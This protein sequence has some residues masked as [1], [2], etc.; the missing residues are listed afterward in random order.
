LLLFLVPCIAVV[1]LA[2][3]AGRVAYRHLVPEWR[4]VEI[5]W[6]DGVMKSQSIAAV[7]RSAKAVVLGD[8]V[9]LRGID[10]ACLDSSLG[11]TANLAFS[12]AD[13][14]SYYTT[15]AAIQDLGVDTRAVTAI[16]VAYPDFFAAWS[17]ERA[18]PYARL[19]TTPAGAF[20]LLRY[21]AMTS[22]QVLHRVGEWALE[23]TWY[24]VFPNP[25]QA[26]ALRKAAL[27]ELPDPVR[28]PAQ[29]IAEPL[30]YCSCDEEILPYH[31][32]EWSVESH[33][34]TSGS[35]PSFALRPAP[36]TDEF[37][38]R[39]DPT[40]IPNDYPYTGYGEV[41]S[42]LASRFSR[43]FLVSFPDKFGLADR[44]GFDAAMRRLAEQ[45]GATYISL[46]DLDVSTMFYD[47][48][49]ATAKG[50]RLVSL[51]LADRIGA[52]LD[53]GR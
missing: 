42:F 23:E 6:T 2:G 53:N 35:E 52:V 10:A 31:R 41:L 47:E 15:V 4:R 16:V 39:N 13:L 5:E 33:R 49:H 7:V 28:F 8:S 3:L 38:K 37:S 14:A 29:F 30:G 17:A 43:V 48:H 1:I 9:A 45:G 50:M 34:C 12:S 25:V 20:H 26:T 21:G 24:Q 40:G 18:A 44:D 19:S 46:T 11:R 32:Q 36:A 22:W 51:M 27:N